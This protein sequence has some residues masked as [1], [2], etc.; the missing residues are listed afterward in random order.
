MLPLPSN[1]DKTLWVSKAFKSKISTSGSHKL[2]RIWR[3]IGVKLGL[4]SSDT[5]LEVFWNNICASEAGTYFTHRIAA[6]LVAVV[7]ADQEAGVSPLHVEICI[8]SDAEV[9]VWHLGDVLDVHTDRHKCWTYIFVNLKFSAADDPSVSQ[10]R[11]WPLR[12]F[13]W[14]KAPTSA[15]QPARPLWLLCLHPNFMSTYHGL[16]PV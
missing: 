9:L 4:S 11:R 7:A 15:N 13:S 5:C 12:A 10:S 16:T 2:W 14:L 6:D 1:F 3:F 8:Q